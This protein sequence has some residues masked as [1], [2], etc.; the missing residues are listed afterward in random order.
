MAGHLPMMPILNRVLCN[1]YERRTTMGKR[2]P[3]STVA[4]LQVMRGLSADEAF[5]I[6]L[7]PHRRAITL[8]CYRMLGSLEEAEEIAQ[9]SLLRAWQRPDERRSPGASRAGP[10][11]TPPNPCLDL[12]KPRRRRTLPPLLAPPATPGAVLGPTSP[13]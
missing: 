7:E 4:S 10:S 2:K 12:L 1:A 11:K 13:D 6:E 3:E 5:R 8:H 9:E